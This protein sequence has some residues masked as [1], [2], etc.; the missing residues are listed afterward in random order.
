MDQ[1]L[2]VWITE[3]LEKHSN[4]TTHG[5]I[6]LDKLNGDAGSRQ[7]F[8][9]NTQ[10]PLLGVRAPIDASNSAQACYFAKISKILHKQGIPTPQII[11]CNERQ[12][13]LLIEDFGDNDFLSMLNDES[14]DLLYSEALMVLLRM[15]QIQPESLHELGLDLPNYS[16]SLLRKEMMLFSEWFVE[17]LLGK[18][19]TSDEHKLIDD[20]FRFLEQQAESQPQVLVHRDY[21]SRNI[22]YREGEAPGIIDFQDAI[23]GPITYDLVSLLRDCYIEWPAEQVKRWLLSY[24]NLAT[25]LGLIDEVSEEQWLLW[26]D[27]MGLQRHIKVL[28]IF[29]RLALRDNKSG[30]LKDLTLTWRYMMSV[31]QQY[32]EMK[33]FVTWCESQLLPLIEQQEWY[34]VSDLSG[35]KPSGSNN[36]T[37]SGEPV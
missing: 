15:Q 21:H 36:L 2:Q 33:S 4:I 1:L 10:P 12:N 20:A 28:G 26:F 11:A 13:F 27:T 30:Y 7:Y 24:G 34:L 3:E 9:V 5:P 22:M 23:W 14:V 16:Q 35:E 25:E 32:P 31:A 6:R 19:L 37:K 29:A 8:R 18:V 17:K